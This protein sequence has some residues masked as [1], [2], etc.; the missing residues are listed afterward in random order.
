MDAFHRCPEFE[1]AKILSADLEQSVYRF[2]LTHTDAAIA[3]AYRPD[4]TGLCDNTACDGHDLVYLFRPDISYADDS[5]TLSS[6]IMEFWGNFAHKGKP[7]SAGGVNWKRFK[8]VNP[9]KELSM[10]LDNPLAMESSRDGSACEFWEGTDFSWV[11]FK[12]FGV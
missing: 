1:T 3:S 12:D 4:L 2:A 9:K 10:S 8:T 11:P 5:P 6:Q 7:G